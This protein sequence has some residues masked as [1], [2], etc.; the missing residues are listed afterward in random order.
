[1]E[2]K[3]I[4]IYKLSLFSNSEIDYNEITKILKVQPTEISNATW[5]LE[6]I[7]N[8]DDSYFDYVGFFYDIL[9]ENLDNLRLLEIPAENIQ[10]HLDF[11]Y[12][13]QCNLEYHKE[14]L[15]KLAK[16]GAAF[17]ISCYDNTN[18]DDYPKRE[19]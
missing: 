6:K 17:T 14:D 9:I 15:E 5:E 10:I 7:E 18:E 8:Y 11:F 2:L 12:D 1:M 13:G 16:L 4:K 19:L 3:H